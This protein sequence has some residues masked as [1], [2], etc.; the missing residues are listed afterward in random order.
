MMKVVIDTTVYVSAFLRPSRGGVSFDLLNV[1]K[2]G[3][4]EL[5]IS[6]RILDEL[7]TTLLGERRML[8]RY[9]YGAA[10]VSDYCQSLREFAKLVADVPDVRGIV[11]RDPDDDKIVACALAAAA[12]Y[13]ITRDRDL[14][15]LERHDDIVMITPEAFLRLLRAQ[16]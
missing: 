10:A 1:A 15:S 5:Y 7:A 4:F 12:D 13:L 11:R 3:K 16:A 6:E 14:L 9:G 8:D 2:E